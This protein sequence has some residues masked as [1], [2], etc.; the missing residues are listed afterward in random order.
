[1]G[2]DFFKN[3]FSLG[4]FLPRVM[5]YEVELIPFG[6]I[7]SGRWYLA[8]SLE[9]TSLYQA[10]ENRSRAFRLKVWLERL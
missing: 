5:A 8:W 9:R 3:D 6:F 10:E 4:K 2:N 7:F 1:M